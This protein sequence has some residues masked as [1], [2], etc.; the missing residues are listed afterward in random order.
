MLKENQ[1]HKEEKQKVIQNGGYPAYTADV[2]WWTFSNQ[3][4]R[5]ACKKFQKLDFTSY[6]ICIGRTI[7]ESY[8][9]CRLVRH[10][11]G[12]KL[13]IVD[14]SQSCDEAIPFAK[15]ICSTEPYAIE[16]PTSSDD[17]LAHIEIIDRLKD[18]RNCPMMVMC[19]EMCANRVLFKQF[20]KIRSADNQ[21]GFDFW[22]VNV[23]RLGGVNEA[24]A[25]YF[26]AKKHNS[27]F[28]I[29]NYIFI[30]F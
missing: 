25:V 10:V 4:V 21:L 24:L 12:K 11:I 9:R 2:G 8:Q 28:A 23:G 5:S 19:G 30:G 22:N 16:D 1:P 27:K 3:H 6:K 13:L 29:N 15:G 18:I 7:P 14:A 26:M 20:L 17:V